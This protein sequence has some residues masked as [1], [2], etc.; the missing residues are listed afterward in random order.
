MV[1]NLCNTSNRIGQRMMRY[2]TIGGMR[3]TRT[4]E[5]SSL[6]LTFFYDRG[7]GCRSNVWQYIFPSGELSTT[8]NDSRRR[9]LLL[10]CIG[11]RMAALAK[12]L[13]SAVTSM[14]YTI[15][16]TMITQK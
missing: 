9:F 7:I 3:S 5:L 8:A 10:F 11:K 12:G 13:F 4:I 6:A 16:V 15:T 2:E 14:H 1:Q